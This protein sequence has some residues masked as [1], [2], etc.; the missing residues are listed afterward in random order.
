MQP[1]TDSVK[2]LIYNKKKTLFSVFVLHGRSSK[3]IHG[4]ILSKKN[5]KHKKSCIKKLT[6]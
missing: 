4:L 5:G 6:K 1:R 2:R 3:T